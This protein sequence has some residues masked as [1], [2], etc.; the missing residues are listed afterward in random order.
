VPDNGPRFRYWWRSAR[1]N[2][3]PPADG[4]RGQAHISEV[5]DFCSATDGFLYV[6]TQ[7]AVRRIDPRTGEVTTWLH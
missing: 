5:R 6:L 3:L 4:G 1:G 2:H 7:G